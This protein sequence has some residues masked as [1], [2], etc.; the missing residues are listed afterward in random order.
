MV[1]SKNRTLMSW[2]IGALSFALLNF[3]FET[4]ASYFGLSTSVYSEV[5]VGGEY[6]EGDTLLPLGWFLFFAE[7]T[8]AIRIGVAVCYGNFRDGVGGDSKL[9][10]V[11]VAGCL[12]AYALLDTLVW[13]LFEKEI[14]RSV[15]PFIYNLFELALIFGIAS[16]GYRIS[17][18]SLSPE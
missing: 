5:L 12:G 15:H 17:W 13:E 6:R 9:L 1:A 16:L 11:V 4:I 8:I 18:V 10:W 3:G 2:L 14:R 7:I